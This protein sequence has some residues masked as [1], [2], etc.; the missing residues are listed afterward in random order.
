MQQERYRYIV[1]VVLRLGYTYWD[2]KTQKGRGGKYKG[3]TE[4]WSE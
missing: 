2:R 1:I 3:G 4:A